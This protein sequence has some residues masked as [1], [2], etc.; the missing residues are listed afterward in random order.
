MADET[1]SPPLSP[2]KAGSAHRREEGRGGGQARGWIAENYPGEPEDSP[3]TV[4][5]AVSWRHLW[6]CVNINFPGVDH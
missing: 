2:H 5:G 3:V 6:S 4:P 1:L